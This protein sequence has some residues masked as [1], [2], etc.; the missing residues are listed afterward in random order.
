MEDDGIENDIEVKDTAADASS[1]GNN[2]SS[3]SSN[4]SASSSSSSSN[5]TDNGDTITVDES[6]KP[7]GEVEV[8][9]K[10]NGYRLDIT[11]YNIG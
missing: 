3:S 5:V 2:N 4:N 1:G 7:D 6:L 8:S 9:E 10:Q 11:M